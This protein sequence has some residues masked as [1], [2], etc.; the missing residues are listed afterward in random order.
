V[1]TSKAKY[2]LKA[3]IDLAVQEGAGQRRPVFIADIAAR[4][5]IPRRFLESI[6]LHL[7]NEGLVVSHR[8]KMGGYA[9]ARAA[10]LITFA[11]VVRAI[12]GPLALTPCTSRTAYQRCEDCRDEAACAIRKTLVQARD[13]LADVLERATLA[14]AI[15]A[16]A[17]ARLRDDK[18]S[19][20]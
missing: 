20:G 9:L 10:D 2:A 17:F 8:G 3:M 14:Q 12:D 6:L 13:A 16:S 5:N 19:A 1:L 18:R 4:Q 15:G 11:D 7:R